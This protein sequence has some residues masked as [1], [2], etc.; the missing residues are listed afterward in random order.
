M[1]EIKY[2]CATY[3]GVPALLREDGDYV[4]NVKAVSISIFGQRCYGDL[5]GVGSERS[6]GHG[7]GRGYSAAGI[8][9]GSAIIIP[10]EFIPMTIVEVN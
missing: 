3:W 8:D 4:H 5:V 6:I 2:K 1:S 7:A 9:V 10:Q